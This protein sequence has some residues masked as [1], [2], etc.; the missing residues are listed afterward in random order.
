MIVVDQLE[1]LFTLCADEQE[2]RVFIDWLW[3]LSK[4][5]TD[6]R[7]LAL[8]VCGLR[9]DFYA[10]CANYPQLREALQAGQTLVGP[11]SLAEIREAILYPAEAVGLD[12][13]AGLVELLLRD[14][15]VTDDP[16]G[17]AEVSAGAYDA[18][19]L[20]LL[21][22]ALQATWQQRQGHTLTVDGYRATGGIRHAI[23]TTA[24]RTFSRLDSAGRRDT[25]SLFLRLVRI[26]D[27]GEDVRRPIQRGDLLRDSR[28]PDI[29]QTVLDAYTRIRLLTQTRDAVEITHEALI[30]EWPR[31][32][33]WIDSDRAGNL[34]RQDLEEAAAS[35]DHE[36]GDAS[37]LYRG[38]RLDAARIW[39][40]DHDHDLAPIARAFLTTSLRHQRRSTAVRRGISAALAMLAVLATTTAVFAIQ[41]RTTALQQ[42]NQAIYNQ[43]TGEAFQ[44]SSNDPSLAA[45][46]NLTAYRMRLT[47]DLTPRSEL[48]SRLLGTENTPLFTPLAAN[49]SSVGAS[50]IALSPDGHTMASGGDESSEIRLWDVSNPAKPSALGKPLAGSPEGTSSLA[51]SPNGQTLAAGGLGGGVR[52]WDVTDPSHPRALG[53]PLTAGNPSK[54]V[55]SVTFSAHRHLLASSSYLG[56]IQLW[57]V[58]D[59]AH[60]RALGKPLIGNSGRVATVAFS[61]DGRTL[62]SGGDHKTIR[63]WDM[64]DPAHPRAIGK[65]LLRDKASNDA[66]WSVAFS[67][68][69]RTLAS[70]SDDGK[71]RMW[72]VSNTSRPQV[73]GKPLQVGNSSGGV[74]SVTFSPDGTTLADSN[75]H[76]A[77]QLWD[78]VQPAHPQVMGNLVA[79]SSVIFGVS[80]TFSPVGHTLVSSADNGTIRLWNLPQPILTANGGI[81]DVMT[82]SPDGHT[83]ASNSV[84]FSRKG[85]DS[86]IQLWD[87]ADPAH[88]RPL[89]KPLIRYRTVVFNPAMAFS[90]DGRIL[91]TG[92]SGNKFRLWDVADAAYPRPLGKPLT[93]AAAGNKGVASLAFSPDGHT[94]VNGNY[95]GT[96]R[97]WLI[98]NPAHPHP[99]G[100][101][102]TAFSRR[103]GITLLAFSPDSRTLVSDSDTSNEIR[104]WRVSDPARPRALG[105]PHNPTNTFTAVAF[106]PDGRTLASGDSAGQIRLWDVANPA[107]LRALGKPLTTGKDHRPGRL[108]AGIQPGRPHTS[109]RFRRHSSP[110]ERHRLPAS[111]DD[112]ETLGRCR[113]RL[114]FD[115]QTGWQLDSQRERGG[116]D[117]ALGVECQLRYQPCMRHNK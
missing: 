86:V 69:G 65:P 115:V 27:S 13:E 89:G 9:A 26:G 30:R 66:V 17:R 81:A 85:T 37:A 23:A 90:P 3:R 42:R 45:Q 40:S 88:P 54:G 34:L 105:K 36:H 101:P 71:V 80:V 14:L 28:Q 106:T 55:S 60:P 99:L 4:P 112:H 57:D 20:P 82:F 107:Y 95:D 50:P 79:P 15:G 5:S 7:P 22:H 51:F 25:R 56:T 92:A 109:Q 104:L 24:E 59:P 116:H 100:K 11:M 62:A 70:G 2:R 31:L 1:E 102:L 38:S 48:A 61:P 96:V 21:A 114:L 68:D 18:G 16:V 12:I 84:T 58:T 6:E 117:P 91:A 103:T 47:S 87:V 77:V 75:F 63:L 108:F 52:L 8:V 110:V 33:Q 64:T 74:S 73:L 44:L 67:P 41:Q 76:G 19:R 113:R 43:I 32:R 29:T 98:T 39:A 83:L 93:A 94:L 35:W 49:T 10:E 78:V 46:L 111:A 97:F 53:K 72:N